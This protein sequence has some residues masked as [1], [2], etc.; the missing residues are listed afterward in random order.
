[1]ITMS[2]QTTKYT[3]KSVHPDA[4]TTKDSDLST[5]RTDPYYARDSFTMRKMKSWQIA[6]LAIFAAVVVGL[7]LLYA[8]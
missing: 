8:W 2:E 1:V 4:H 3:Q 6:A 5:K 7:A